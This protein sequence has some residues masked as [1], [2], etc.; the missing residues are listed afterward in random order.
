MPNITHRLRIASLAGFALPHPKIKAFLEQHEWDKISRIKDNGIIAHP[1]DATGYL[2]GTSGPALDGEV[3]DAVDLVGPLAKSTR[4]R[5]SI[6]SFSE[7]TGS[8]PGVR[9]SEPLG[10]NIPG[11]RSTSPLGLEG[12]SPCRKKDCNGGM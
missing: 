5:Q 3:K 4:V 2:W 7:I 6:I 8:S 12:V 9:Y 1:V 10:Y 11:V